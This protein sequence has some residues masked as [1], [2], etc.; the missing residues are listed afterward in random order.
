MKISTKFV[1]FMARCS[2]VQV[3]YLNCEFRSPE[4]LC[5]GHRAWLLLPYRQI[6]FSSILLE[7]K[8]GG[9]YL[10]AFYVMSSTQ[11]VELNSLGQGLRPFVYCGSIPKTVVR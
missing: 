3:L 9:G 6:I 2:G 5:L 11:T 1:T 10:N 4:V 7:S 8:E